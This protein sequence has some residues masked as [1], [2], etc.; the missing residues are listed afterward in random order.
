MEIQLSKTS[1]L[2]KKH[3]K[4]V[5]DTLSSIY[6][7]VF[8]VSVISS[9]ALLFYTQKDLYSIWS[10]QVSDPP[11]LP[12][13]FSPTNIVGPHT[14]GDFQLPYTLALTSNPYDW[15]FYNVTM[16][17]GFM[18]FTLLTIFPIKSATFIFLIVGLLFFGKTLVDYFG[19][20]RNYKMYSSIFLLCSLPILICLDRGGLQIIALAFM[21]KGLSWYRDNSTIYSKQNKLRSNFYLAVAVSMKIYLILPLI[22]II[23]VEKKT[24]V[25]LKSFTGIFLSANLFLS[26]FYGG[27]IKV[28][29]GLAQGYL[30]QTGNT[31]PGWIFGGV[32]FSKFIASV[33]FYNHSFSESTDFATVYQRYVF[34]PGLLYFIAIFF[35]VINQEFKSNYKIAVILTTIFLVTPVSGAYTLV[36]T[37]FMLAV[38][39]RDLVDYHNFNWKTKARYLVLIFC[40]FLSMLPIPSKYYLTIIPGIWLVHL[41]FL[42]FFGFFYRSNFLGD[43]STSNVKRL[44]FLSRRKLNHKI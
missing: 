18:L 5:R 36:T 22:L 8:A 32:S 16:P 6:L 37:S 41:F 19:P 44:K 27:P 13:G 29:K 35:L 10:F 34:L 31:D 38:V 4:D 42:V 39:F 33:Y 26:F 43:K 20:S 15:S 17:L 14:F 23:F 24:L 7:V 21:F 11:W 12:P 40:I 1:N 9:L 2:Q 30:F 25:F 28:V 3:E